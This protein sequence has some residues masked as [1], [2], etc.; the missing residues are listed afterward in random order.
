MS[1][2]GGS[3]GFNWSNILI[4]IV[5]IIIGFVGTLLAKSFRSGK[6]E[7]QFEGQDKLF[8]NMLTNSVKEQ[9]AIKDQVAKNCVLINDLN[10]RMTKLETILAERDKFQRGA[11]KGY[12]AFRDMQER[13]DERGH[14][15][16]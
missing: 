4:P 14:D 1:T 16:R 11:D 5:S 12:G 9:L 13:N 2:A 10:V 7:G 8:D 15:W 3:D 6:K